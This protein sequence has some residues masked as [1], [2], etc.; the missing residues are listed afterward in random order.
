[1]F[2]CFKTWFL[3]ANVICIMLIHTYVYIYANV[4]VQHFSRW[5][6]VS[7]QHSSPFLWLEVILPQRTELLWTS[8]LSFVC[9]FN[10]L[11]VSVHI[12]CL[13][14]SLCYWELQCHNSKV[15]FM[16]RVK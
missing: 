10:D 13:S 14:T 4:Y 2:L 7:L 6:I 11:L 12:S 8:S 15:I 5:A 16:C 3:C 9:R 1:L